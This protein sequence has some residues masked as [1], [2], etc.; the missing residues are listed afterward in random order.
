MK[1]CCK[2][3]GSFIC[4]VSIQ[5]MRCQ[6]DFAGLLYQYRKIAF[7]FIETLKYCCKR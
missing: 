6:D 7:F 5:E 4:S 1:D 2:L 3:L